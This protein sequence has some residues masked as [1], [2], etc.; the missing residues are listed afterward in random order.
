[1]FSVVFRACRERP[2]SQI[3][4]ERGRRLLNLFNGFGDAYWLEMKNPRHAGQGRRR[5][6][7]P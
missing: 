2:A 1:M 6:L 5:I 3:G 4:L 7:L